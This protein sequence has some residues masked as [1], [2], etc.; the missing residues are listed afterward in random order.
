MKK[1]NS[2][3]SFFIKRRISM[4]N[5]S[6]TDGGYAKIICME[7]D[8]LTMKISVYPGCS[9]ECCTQP[10]NHLRNASKANPGIQ[11]DEASATAIVKHF[12]GTHHLGAWAIWNSLDE[13]QI[14]ACLSLAIFGNGK[15][16]KVEVWRCRAIKAG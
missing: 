16:D 7:G 9:G 10:L 8:K 1:V 6:F 15:R 12:R 14:A 11:W 2:T 13:E 4:L 3:Q 5:V